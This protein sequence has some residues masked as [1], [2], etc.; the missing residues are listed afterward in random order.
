MHIYNVAMCGGTYGA[1]NLSEAREYSGVWRRNQDTHAELCH[2]CRL[3]S[4]WWRCR[5]RYFSWRRAS[6]SSVFA[7]SSSVPGVVRSCPQTTQTRLRSCGLNHSK[8]STHSEMN[9]K[10]C[11]PP[12]TERGIKVSIVVFGE[13]AC[14]LYR[15]KSFHRNRKPGAGSSI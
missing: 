4:S 11:A 10:P 3:R 7:S 8:G 15:S 12:S 6:Y 9:H 13:C 5:L 1:R 14:G 2:L